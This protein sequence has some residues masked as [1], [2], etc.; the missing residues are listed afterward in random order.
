MATSILDLF[1]IGREEFF[2]SLGRL[3]VCKK[4][5]QVVSSLASLAR[6]SL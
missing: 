5:L 4:K 3:S 1:D 2:E 6:L